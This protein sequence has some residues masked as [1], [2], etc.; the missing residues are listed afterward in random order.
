MTDRAEKSIPSPAGT[1]SVLA[2]SPCLPI[3]CDLER[4][5]H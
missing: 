4:S 5:S 1:P 2:V 3:A